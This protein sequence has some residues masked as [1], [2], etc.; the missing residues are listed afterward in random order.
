MASNN[1][2]SSDVQKP[3]TRRGKRALEN[4]APKLSENEKT[5]IFVR[6]GQCGQEVTQFLKDIYQLKKPN[7][8]FLKYRNPIHPFEDETPLERFGTKYDASLF[9]FGSHSKKRP[10]NVVFGRMNRSHLLDAFEFSLEDFQS[11]A[12]F[13]RSTA[14]VG[15]KPCLTFVG[16]RFYND[17]THIRLRNFFTDFLRGPDVEQLR[18][19]GVETLL[20]FYALPDGSVAMRGYKIELKKSGTRTPRV[21]LAETGPSCRFEFRRNRLASNESFKAACRQPKAAKIR[22]TKNI[23]RDVF[24]TKLG[25]VHVKQQ[26]LAQLQTRKVRALKTPREKAPAKK[27]KIDQTAE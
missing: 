5:T 9:A 13:K 23:S 14:P 7:A 22:V 26:D 18:L 24:G 20:A 25:R 17:P 3:R 6:G 27:R 16:E 2:G 10:R 21:E 8:V 4:R 15:S 19:Q 12:S 11:L 1:F